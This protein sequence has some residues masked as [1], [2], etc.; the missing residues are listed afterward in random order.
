M[1]PSE[2]ET[3][4]RSV[5]A[6]ACRENKAHP[7]AFPLS[8]NYGLVMAL[9]RRHRLGPLFR[10]A[11]E[12]D[13]RAA[14][15][16]PP[17]LRKQL[18]L[19][20]QRSSAVALL[21]EQMA[22]GASQALEQAGVRHAFFKAV[23]LRRTVYAPASLRPA[24]DIDLLVAAGERHRAR[25]ALLRRGFTTFDKKG[26]ITH[27]ES[28]RWRGGH[29]DL[30]WTLFRPGRGRSDLAREVIEAAT[31]VRGLPVVSPVHALGVGLLGTALGDY[32]SGKLIRAVDIDR[33]VR[34]LDP[35]WEAATDW[36]AR[37]GLQPAA[38]LMLTWV[39]DWL[40]T[41]VPHRVW[42]AL[43]PGWVRRRYLLGWLR[44]DPWRVYCRS[45]MVARTAFS[46]ALHQS[47]RDVVRA[48]LRRAMAFAR[49]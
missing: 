41:P 5:V 39:Q 9:L 2:S 40:G 20:H 28:L 49:P 8:A 23:Q 35:D 1:I 48:A 16:L 3:L 14:S 13:S 37:Q 19:L 10:A 12:S 7:E 22:L 45:P 21:Q 30:H 27:E 38:W 15:F 6:F 17:D 11:V 24:D 26:P 44:L 46:L 18:A 31:V 29:L 4:L 34:Q 43:A 32:V 36:V 42:K 25:E 33:I 47:A